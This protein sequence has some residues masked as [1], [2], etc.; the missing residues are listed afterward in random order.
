MKI[1]KIIFDYSRI[2][3]KVIQNTLKKQYTEYKY[4]RVIKFLKKVQN[5]WKKIE[6]NV[7]VAIVEASKLEWVQDQIVIY[8][9]Y[10]FPVVSLSRP[11]TIRTVK[12]PMYIENLIHELIHENIHPYL[13]GTKDKI[14]KIYQK[15]PGIHVPVLLIEK[16]VY[17]KVFE[18]NIAEKRF[19]FIYSLKKSSAYPVIELVREIYPD[20]AKSNQDVLSFIKSI[21]I[22]SHQ[23]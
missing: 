23:L 9:V 13:R 5:E 15:N 6:T 18:K 14:L 22:S 12:N 3:D 4:R 2:Y 20:F 21:Q 7:L 16:K 19:R 8:F 17:E 10:D 1:P 11:L